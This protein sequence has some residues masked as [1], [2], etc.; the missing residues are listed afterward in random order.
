MNNF[1]AVCSL[2]GESVACTIEWEDNSTKA[3]VKVAPHPCKMEGMTSI[4]IATLSYE[5][6]YINVSK[7]E[8]GIE[9]VQEGKD[10]PAN[11]YWDVNKSD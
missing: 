11:S 2:C 10:T 7:V 6:D 4:E 8:L 3:I 5:G 1:I 9:P